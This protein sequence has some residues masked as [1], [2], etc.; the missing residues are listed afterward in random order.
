MKLCNFTKT[1]K[2]KKKSEIQFISKIFNVLTDKYFWIAFF[3]IDI[4]ARR[5]KMAKW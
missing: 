5:A 1:A 3:S 2:L 4:D